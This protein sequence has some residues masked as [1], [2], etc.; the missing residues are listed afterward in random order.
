MKNKKAQKINKRLSRKNAIYTAGSSTTVLINYSEE[1]NILEVEFRESNKIY[2]YL[3]VEPLK[4]AAYKKVIKNKGS[5]GKFVNGKIK[6]YY[7][8]IEIKE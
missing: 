7:E 1:L 2:Q 4:W 5:S 6:P 8:Y 3:K